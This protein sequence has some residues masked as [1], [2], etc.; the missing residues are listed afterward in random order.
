MTQASTAVLRLKRA[1]DWVSPV[2]AWRELGAVVRDVPGDPDAIDAEAAAFRRMANDLDYAAAD[3]A[4]LKLTGVWEG[5]AADAAL[6]SL[7]PTRDQLEQAC[8]TMRKAATA[9]ENYADTLRRLKK[10]QAGHRR[11]LAGARNP[12]D[13]LRAVRGGARV[14]AELQ[15]ASNSLRRAMAEAES[16]ARA[17]A[18]HCPRVNASDAVRLAQTGILTTAQLKRAGEN[19][20]ALSIHDNARMRALLDGCATDAERAYLLKALAAG[21]P[22]AAIEAFAARIHGKAPSWLQRQLSLVSAGSS[23]P[24][25]YGGYPI[26][27]F[28]GTTCGSAS[29]LI[30]RA[31]NDPLYALSLTTEAGVPLDG[32]AFQDRL[33]A[34]Q[35]RIHDSTNRIWPQ[36]L[37]TSPWGLVDE[38]NRHG[39][40]YDWRIVDDTDRRCVTSALHDAVKAV[41]AGHTVPVL[42]GDGIPR[43]YVLLIGHEGGNLIFYNPSGE[44][45]RVSES[46][47]RGG[48]LSALGYRHVQGV[49]TPR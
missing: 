38:L 11:D 46:D 40:Q 10:E 13:A 15:E 17:G 7:K 23:G 36:Q 29:I 45:V 20:A 4:G 32:N 42:I 31:C 26:K 21:H 6:A 39:P 9:L 37:G 24:A 18:I 41:D 8:T 3:A 43:H 47:F 28:D 44:I 14:L 34:E 48:D 27:Q 16:G 2:H 49:V 12:A 35:Q 30:A 19:L 1:A 25:T 33:R 5:E 22:I